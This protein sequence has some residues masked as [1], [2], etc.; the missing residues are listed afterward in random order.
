MHFEKRFGCA[1]HKHELLE[2]CRI[3]NDRLIEIHQPKLVIVAG[4]GLIGTMETHYDLRVGVTRSVR[5]KR[6]LVELCGRKQ[7]WVAIPHPT[8]ARLHREQIDKIASF[9]SARFSGPA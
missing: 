3:A 5:G 4:L 2:F 9:V 8:G 1:L 7:E 6:T